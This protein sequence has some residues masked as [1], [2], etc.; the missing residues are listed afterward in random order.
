MKDAQILRPDIDIRQVQQP[1]GNNIY[2]LYLTQNN[3][4]DNAS[5]YPMVDLATNP[6]AYLELTDKMLGRQEPKLEII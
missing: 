2:K 4:E 1:T 5:I 3:T 6:M